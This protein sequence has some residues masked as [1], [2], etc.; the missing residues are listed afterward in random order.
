MLYQT[1]WHTSLVTELGRHR[2]VDLHEFQASLVYKSEF[3]HRETL[4]QRA[5]K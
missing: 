2:Q 3:G 1:W 4:S 5:N